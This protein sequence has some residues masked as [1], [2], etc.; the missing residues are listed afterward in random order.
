[1][2]GSSGS[3]RATGCGVLKRMPFNRNAMP[4]ED[5]EIM[6]LAEAADFLR[7]S[8]STMHQRKEIPRYRIPGSREYRYLRS[9]LLAWLKGKA[10]IFDTSELTTAVESKTSIDGSSEVTSPVIDIYSKRVYHR[11]S[12]Y[13]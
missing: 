4:P 6:N 2:R 11:N 12:R 10:V 7:L 5:R 8:I 13:R 1:M 9:E 3:L